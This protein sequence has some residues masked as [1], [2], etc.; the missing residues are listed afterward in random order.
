MKST[1]CD[2]TTLILARTKR[3]IVYITIKT[4]HTLVIKASVALQAVLLFEKFIEYFWNFDPE[5]AF[6]DNENENFPVVT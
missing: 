2:E 1:L 6:L 5:N 4:L 3:C